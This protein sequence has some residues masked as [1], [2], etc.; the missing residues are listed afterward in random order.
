M[1][2]TKTLPINMIYNNLNSSFLNN[3]SL[4]DAFQLL[5]FQVKQNMVCLLTIIYKKFEFEFS[6]KRVM[7]Q[8]LNCKVKVYPTH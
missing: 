4:I 1:Q 5:T 8:V 2:Y 6:N 7:F 3:C